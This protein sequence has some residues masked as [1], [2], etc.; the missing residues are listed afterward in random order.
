MS[1]L[2][3]PINR[4]AANHKHILILIFASKTQVVKNQN[5]PLRNRTAQGDL[6]KSIE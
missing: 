3:A 6:G 1:E 2:I 5:D 4:V